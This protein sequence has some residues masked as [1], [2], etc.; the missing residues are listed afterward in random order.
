MW[1]HAGWFFPLCSAQL[2]TPQASS[3]KPISAMLGLFEGHAH[4]AASR[5]LLVGYCNLPLPSSDL[6]VFSLT[7][8]SGFCW[9]K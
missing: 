8:K 2:P 7:F 9:K 3:L 1:A 5:E 4:G 6:C